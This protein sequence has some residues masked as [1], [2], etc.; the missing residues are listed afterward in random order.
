MDNPYDAPSAV[1]FAAAE[2]RRPLGVSILAVL[3]GVLGLILLAAFIVLL[4]NWRENNEFAI[5]RRL[6]PSIF[7][8]FTGLSVVL[9]FAT[10]IG[11]W[12]GRKWGWWLACTGFVLFVIQNVG[13]VILVNLSSNAS[14]IAAFLSVDSLKFLVRGIIF[15]GILAYWLRRSVQRYFD[16]EKIGRIKAVVLAAVSGI[17]ITLVITVVLQTVFLFRTW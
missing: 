11:M 15:V 4:M 9:A 1:P 14:S 13:S 16:L 3:T 6:A 5:N 7:W 17:R 8:F 10:S 12:Q 2:L